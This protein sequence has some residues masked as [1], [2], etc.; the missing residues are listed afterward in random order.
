MRTKYLK[1]ILL[2]VF[3]GGCIMSVI[4]C[5]EERHIKQLSIE[6]IERRT[7]QELIIEAGEFLRAKP[8]MARTYI[9]LVNGQALV[10]V[11]EVKI[12]NEQATVILKVDVIPKAVRLALL[13]II[14]THDSQKDINFNINDA[15]KL[16][17][18]RQ[19][20]SPDA[21][22]G[23]KVTLHLRKNGEWQVAN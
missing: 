9:E 3:F 13:N 1:K 4:G 21:M 15:I 10:E 19:G 2:S 20:L 17:R 6:T 7:T 11:Q 23:K 12:F 18:S 5:T 22:E 14:S 16:I 8:A